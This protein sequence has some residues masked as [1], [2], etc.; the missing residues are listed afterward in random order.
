MVLVT[1]LGFGPAVA[2]AMS[3]LRGPTGELKT[4]PM[5]DAEPARGVL[6]LGAVM[7]SA[8]VLATLGALARSW[9]L[10]SIL[11]G[12]VVGWAAW[13]GATAFDVLHEGPGAS[14]LSR[15]T[16]EAAA[17]GLS[18]VGILWVVVTL[19][20]ARTAR[21]KPRVPLFT[22]LW[23]ASLSDSGDWMA[24]MVLGAAGGVLCNLLA[25]TTLKGQSLA[26]ATLAGLG[27]GA[28]SVLAWAYRVDRAEEGI[29]KLRAA[30]GHEGDLGA[31][32]W[33]PAVLP[34]ACA[35]ALLG[36]AGPLAALVVHG[37]AGTAAAVRAEDGLFVLARVMPL[38]WA[39][40]TLLG[41]PLG[42]SWASAMIDKRS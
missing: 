3:L 31:V 7:A 37:S 2:S 26:S 17:A 35:A 20:M 13:R 33:M 32:A 38:D 25:F 39:T 28:A 1:L 18:V 16:L 23:E 29:R 24:V 21:G 27:C 34:A 30:T 22:S 36:V 41:V 6:V 10:G 11:G 19:D 42:V 8:G 12:I 15:L 9:S 40:G 5:L 4:T 14:V